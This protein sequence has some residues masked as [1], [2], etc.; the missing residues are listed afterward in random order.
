MIKI[1]K[2]HNADSYWKAN[3]LYDQNR[4]LIMKIKVFGLTVWSRSDSYDCN[5]KKGEGKDGMGFKNG[6]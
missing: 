5:L 1:E 3:E 4:K 6:S 2:S